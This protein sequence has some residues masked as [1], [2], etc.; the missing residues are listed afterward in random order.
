[1]LRQLLPTHGAL[2]CRQ[3]WPGH[4]L[5]AVSAT[6]ATGPGDSRAQG[7]GMHSLAIGCGTTR[8]SVRTAPNNTTAAASTRQVRIRPPFRIDGPCPPL[9]SE[10]QCRENW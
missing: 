8:H 3:F 9:L 10:A 4:G 2:V 1:M 5:E 6:A 7:L